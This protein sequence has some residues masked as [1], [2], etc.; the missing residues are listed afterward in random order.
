[1][2][3]RRLLSLVFMVALRLSAA[4]IIDVSSQSAITLNSGGALRFTIY[5]GNFTANAKNLNLSAV[6][7]DVSF[8]LLSDPLSESGRFTA[9][10]SSADGPVSLSQGSLGFA[11]GFLDSATYRG[12]VSV[13]HGS[14]SFS[15]ETSSKLFDGGS[16]VLTLLYDGPAVT[17]GLSSSTLQKDFHASLSGGPLSVGAVQS[18]VSYIPP[19]QTLARTALAAQ[20]AEVPEPGSG[21]LLAG[22]AAGLWLL[23]SMRRRRT[24]RRL[25]RI[26]AGGI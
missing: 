22:A 25:N 12:T 26:S 5:N 3:L 4:T 17:V 18:R 15:Q 9:I 20:A 19:A 10:L 6:V 7:T 8:D 21:P 23:S 1:M 2:P 16:A 13:L 11:A 24:R 14:F